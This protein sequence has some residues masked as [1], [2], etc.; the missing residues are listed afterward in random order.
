MNGK[1]IA[2]SRMEFLWSSNMLDTR[3]TMKAKYGMVE[4]S[5]LH[6]KDGREEGVQETLLHPLTC[7]VYFKYRENID[8][9]LSMKDRARYLRKVVTTRQELERKLG[10]DG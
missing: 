2:N 3:T 10:T 7:E 6:C 9:W 8:L 5:C 4:L 1:S